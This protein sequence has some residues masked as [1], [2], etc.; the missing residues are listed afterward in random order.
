VSSPRTQNFS[1]TAIEYT[2]DGYEASGQFLVDEL[3][4]DERAVVTLLCA[5][6]YRGLG[7]DLS[8]WAAKHD[9]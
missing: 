9:N 8:S 2:E 7:E 4:A 1:V 3:G 5:R 6:L